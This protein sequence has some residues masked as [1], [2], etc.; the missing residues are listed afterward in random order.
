MIKHQKPV[1]ILEKI[2]KLLKHDLPGG[3][4][5]SEKLTGLVDNPFKTDSVELKRASYKRM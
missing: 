1:M 3:D 2:E 4:E 5:I